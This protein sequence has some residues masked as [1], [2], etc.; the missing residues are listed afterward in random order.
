MN[1]LYQ[2]NPRAQ[3]LEFLPKNAVCAEIG[4]H[5]GDF[6]KEILAYCAPA[7]LHLIDPWTYEQSEVYRHAWY[8]GMARGGQE[9]MDER[10]LAVCT[11]FEPDVR[12]GRV[13][14]HRGLSSEVLSSFPADYF[15]WIYIDGNHFYDFVKRD[16]ELSLEKTR[17]EGYITGDDYMEGKWWQGGVK[18][19]VD[20]FVG[21]RPITAVVIENTQF[22]LQKHPQPR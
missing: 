3:L 22:I 8:G 17:P 1:V 5:L 10:Y 11:L 2:N 19:A 4:V 20:E 21:T 15:D 6:S 14:I 16:L 7:K 18:R 13:Q 9:E 12:D